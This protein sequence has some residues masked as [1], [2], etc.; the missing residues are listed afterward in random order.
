VQNQLR[1]HRVGVEVLTP[2]RMPGDSRWVL[3][4]RGWAALPAMQVLPVIEPVTGR[5][6]LTG[7]VKFVGERQFILGDVI[8]DPL[9]RPL[10]VQKID[11]K[12]VSQALKRDFYPF[13]IRLDAT[14]PHGYVRDWSAA[15]LAA[16]PPERHL[17]YAVQ[18]FAMALTWLVMG[19]LFARKTRRRYP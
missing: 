14:A 5:Q 7:H 1:D 3:V 2:L 19:L 13:V 12:A 17:G 4:D 9:A 11:I 16:I 6:M 10:V 8:P 15:S 18:W